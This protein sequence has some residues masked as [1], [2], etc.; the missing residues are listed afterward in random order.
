M[1]VK[2]LSN[3][4]GCIY[5]MSNFSHPYSIYVVFLLFMY[6][7]FSLGMIANGHVNVKYAPHRLDFYPGDANHTVVSFTRLLRDLEKLL[8]HSSYTLFDGCGTRP[9]YEAMLQRK[10][11]CMSSLPKAPGKP[12]FAK[13]LPRTF[14]MQLDDC[15]KIN[16]Y[17]YIFYFWS[18]L[19]ITNIFKEV[20]VAFLMVGHMHDDINASFGH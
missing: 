8:V 13:P 7:V 12:I 1:C 3:C 9:L 19:V 14:H 5:Q 16:K 18:L 4:V 10:D 15:A 2:G 11:V 20:F 6:C 17:R